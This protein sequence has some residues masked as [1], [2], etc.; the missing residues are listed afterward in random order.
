MPPWPFAPHWHSLH[1]QELMSKGPPLLL[2]RP[3]DAVSDDGGDIAGDT[4]AFG[5]NI[6]GQREELRLEHVLDNLAE[7][8]APQVVLLDRIVADEILD[9]VIANELLILLQP[10]HLAVRQK[11]APSRRRLAGETKAASLLHGLL[12]GLGNHG[13]RCT[14]PITAAAKHRSRPCEESQTIP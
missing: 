1:R 10:P 14:K 7:V 4:A 8:A 11:A 5:S 2:L 3:Q 12:E 9:R 6:L 13:K